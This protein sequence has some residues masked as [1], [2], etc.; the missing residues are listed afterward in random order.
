[1]LPVLHK[2]GTQQANPIK[3][4]MQKCLQLLD[5]EATYPN[6]YFHYHTSAMLLHVDSDE[7]Y[8][9]MP[10]VRSWVAGYYYL[11]G[12]Q[13]DSISNNLNGPILI[14]YKTIR[15]IVVSAAEAEIGDYFIMLDF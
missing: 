1:M 4:T 6:G 10:N 9:V 5:Y 13:T 2:I 12:N 3:K 15:N 8:L 11:S 7:A 14:N